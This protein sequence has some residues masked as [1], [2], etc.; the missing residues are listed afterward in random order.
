MAKH[1]YPGLKD[2]KKEHIKLTK[3]VIQLNE[4]KNYVFS[5]NVADF[6]I[7]WLTN[8]ILGTDKKYAEFILARDPD[9]GQ[10]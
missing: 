2:H 8:H 4:N 9:A 5:D 3:E 1:K 7:A 10:I 6:L